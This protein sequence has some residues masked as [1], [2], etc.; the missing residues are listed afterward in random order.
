MRGWKCPNCRAATTQLRLRRRSSGS[1]SHWSVKKV[2]SNFPSSRSASSQ[3]FVAAFQPGKDDLVRDGS[4]GFI[5][6]FGD[7]LYRAIDAAETLE[8]QGYKVGVVN[9]P[10]LNV[11]DEEALKK[12][13]G[14]GFVLV[15]ETQ[16]QVTGL[17]SRFGTWLLERG[18]TP[19]YKHLGIAKPG[20][21]GGLEQVG[22]HGLEPEH[23]VAAVKELVR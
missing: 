17:G 15:A 11:V 21:G 9:K 12:I 2:R 10:T 16:N 8:E 14:S 5:V 20:E 6:A 22:F 7:T 1:C 4:D 19:R 3:F 18:Y 23:L 13:A